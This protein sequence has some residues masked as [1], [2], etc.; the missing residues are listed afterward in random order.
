MSSHTSFVDH[1][2][3]TEV[4]PTLAAYTAIPCLSPAFD[5][6]WESNG[7]LL[8][9]AAL[10]GEW[11][12]RRPL[13]S[14]RVEVLELEGRSPLLLV[15]V[16]ATA[17]ALADSTVLIYGHLDKQP[18]LGEWR[19]GL[20]PYVAV[21]EGDRLYGRGTVDDGYAVFSAMTALEAL[22]RS[23]EP[24]GRV[25][26]LIEASE[27][28]GSPDLNAHLDALGERLGAPLLLVC[29]DTGCLDYERLWLTSSLRGNVVASVRVDVLTHGLHSG[30]AGAV[31]P[32]SFRVLRQLLDRIEDP[33]TG[34]IVLDELHAEI[35]AHQRQALA[36]L[37][38]D[39]GPAV[40]AGFPVVEGLRLDGKDPADRLVRQSWYPSLAVTGMDG[41]P[42]V[43]D[44]GNV[45]RPSTTAKLSL[46][47]PPTCDARAAA[48]AIVRTL[49]ADPPSGATVSVEIEAPC[50]GWTTTAPAPWLTAALEQASMAAFGR[51]PASCGEGGSIPF[52]AD[53]GHRF[54]EVQF[55]A[56]GVFGP[57]CNAHAP[58][59]FL[60]VPTAKA[61]TEAVADVVTAAARHHLGG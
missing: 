8:R 25:L 50:D 36:A 26:V 20:G 41:I 11:C 42:A 53:L 49:T 18:P 9:A 24:H 16:A 32:S 60:H 55:M 19:Q 1:Q 5:A 52:L 3:E 39:L 34:E 30:L 44:G 47:L 31:V 57:A 61:V 17:P 59:E 28:S 22:E 46:R 51:P 48:D 35:P 15:E 2:F 33:V 40:D 29:L 37:A 6:A 14:H 23:G 54:P 12:A 21:R 27:E 13:A 38:A 45:L 43:A 56:T 58:N 7:A 10:L 4:F